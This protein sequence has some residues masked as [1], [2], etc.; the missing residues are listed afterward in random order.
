MAKTHLTAVA[1][2]PPESARE[3]IQA[4]RWEHDRNFH[5]WMPHVTLLYPFQPKTEFDE[6]A[7]PLAAACAGVA[8]FDVTL[9]EFRLFRHRG[10]LCALWLAPEPLEPWMVLQAALGKAVPD[11][12]DAARHPGGFV[13]H[14]NI[15]QAKGLA[16]EDLRRELQ[17]GWRPVRFQ[18][19]EVAL[20][21]RGDPPEDV[22]QV[23]QTL[24][25]GVG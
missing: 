13:P 1:L 17:A 5:R 3:P 14:L 9:A 7:V 8:P 21:W 10:G 4:I 25:L 12:D 18:A 23:D 2:I 24:P 19:I 6:A 20:I 11:C 22:F 16:A 15:G